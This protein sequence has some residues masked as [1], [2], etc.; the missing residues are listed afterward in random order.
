M[1]FVP[2]IPMTSSFVPAVYVRSSGEKPRPISPASSLPALPCPGKAQGLQFP[3]K[4]YHE[5]SLHGKEYS[6]NSIF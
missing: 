1:V 6:C 2:F 4:Q 3:T 5:E